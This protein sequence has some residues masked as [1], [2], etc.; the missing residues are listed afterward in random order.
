MAVLDKAVQRRDGF[1]DEVSGLAAVQCQ[2]QAIVHA[3][4]CHVADTEHVVLLG[5]KL[6]SQ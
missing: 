5:T 3:H 6:P 4:A 1:R 2:S